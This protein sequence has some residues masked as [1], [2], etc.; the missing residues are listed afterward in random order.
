MLEQGQLQRRSVKEALRA[1]FSERRG[2]GYIPLPFERLRGAFLCVSCPSWYQGQSLRQTIR[3]MCWIRCPLPVPDPVDVVRSAGRGE[4]RSQ[5]L[6]AARAYVGAQN[7]VAF[8]NGGNATKTDIAM[9]HC[10]EFVGLRTGCG[11]RARLPGDTGCKKSMSCTSVFG[12]ISKF[13]F[14]LAQES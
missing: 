1:T 6:R 2:L 4:G 13:A 14:A 3:S 5:R 11:R 8:A 7:L 12:V 10:R 9:L